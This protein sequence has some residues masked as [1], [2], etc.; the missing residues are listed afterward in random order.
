VI[1]SV[2]DTSENLVSDRT[3]A[4][5]DVLDEHHEKRAEQVKME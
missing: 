2:E 5:I 4:R 3:N 1:P